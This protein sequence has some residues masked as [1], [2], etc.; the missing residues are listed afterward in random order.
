MKKPGLRSLLILGAAS[1]LLQ[2]CTSAPAHPEPPRHLAGSPAPAENLD[3]LVEEA[4]KGYDRVNKD[5]E[6][7][8]CKREQPVGSKLWIT[9]CLTEVELREQAENAKKFREDVMK[10]G[11]RCES[12]PG[13]QQG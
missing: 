2:G 12:G 11:R 8:F 13:C 7:M 10:Q 6:L 3:P 5:G 9:R 4:A 1:V